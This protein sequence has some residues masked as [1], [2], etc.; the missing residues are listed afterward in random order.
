MREAI[1]ALAIFVGAIIVMV[2]ALSDAVDRINR[3]IAELQEWKN[4]M[5]GTDHGKL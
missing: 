4:K 2:T 1:I 3:Q 5:G